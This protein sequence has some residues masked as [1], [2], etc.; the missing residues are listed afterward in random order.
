M[1]RFTVHILLSVS[2]LLSALQVQAKD[3]KVGIYPF[4]PFVE[5]NEQ[6][7]KSS[8]MTLDLM[9]LLNKQQQRFNFIPVLISPKRRYASYKHGE[10]DVIFYESRKWGWQSIDILESDVYQTGGEVYVALKQP[11]RDQRYFDDFSG[12][13][14][15][16]MLGYHYGFAQFNSDEHY[17][18]TK[19]NMVLTWDNNKALD[20]ILG[21]RGDVAV[22]TQ[23]FLKRYLLRHPEHQS[24][25]LISGKMDQEYQHTALLRPDIPLSLDDLNAMIRQLKLT[26][27]WQALLSDYGIAEQ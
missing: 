19:Y 2:V 21:Q 4:A 8:G 9:A 11:G 15:V 6:T 14:M 22:V 23:A 20:L 13:R 27:G 3:I 10:F 25:F 7:G 16:G 5:M 18:R 26:P 24:R 12:R 17:L 1:K